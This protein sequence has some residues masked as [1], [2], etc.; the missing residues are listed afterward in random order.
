MLNRAIVMRQVY[1]GRIWIS[2]LVVTIGAISSAGGCGPH[3]F[4]Q[5][6]IDYAQQAAVTD[7]AA[8]HL[9]TSAYYRFDTAILSD[10]DD[11]VSRPPVDVDELRE[12]LR[13]VLRDANELAVASTTN[14][15][16]RMPPTVQDE[17][18]RV[19]GVTPDVA[20]VQRHYVRQASAALQADLQ[21]LE[22]LSRRQLLQ[23]LEQI[24]MHVA[25]LADDQG[26]LVR[27]VLLAW[28]ALPT[29]IGISR[30]E[31]RIAKKTRAKA[32]K[33]FDRVAIDRPY[34][35]SGDELVNRYAP[36][37]AI[38]EPVAR[39]YDDEDDR[40]GAVG[41]VEHAGGIAVRIDTSKPAV[42]GYRTQAKI[43][44]RAY[45]QVNYVWWFPERPPMA[46]NDPVA[47]P[48]DGAMIRITLDDDDR[49]MICESS[50]NCGCGHVVFVSKELESAARRAF[51]PPLDHKRFSV[52][53]HVT[54]RR[55]AVVVGTFETPSAPT[56]P[57][58]LSAA[59]YHEVCR[60]RFPSAEPAVSYTI[61][62]DTSYRLLDYDMLDR[63]PLGQRLGSMFGPDGLVHHAG[64]LE[65]YLLAP[66]G[67]L[68]AGQ[69][70][71]RGTQRIRWDDYMHDD[72]RLMEQLLRIPPLR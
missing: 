39:T 62:Q 68:S 54:G 53:R 16:A 21:E 2:L 33:V 58:V 26:R 41:L 32:D 31:A 23:R 37:I 63:L 11:A 22:R 64:R 51:G 36:V 1:I 17:L 35:G 50:L 38:E 67:I 56:R 42:Y 3:D 15:I 7:A 70:R 9:S 10:I 40:I 45:R 29:A 20:A 24:R 61:T 18:A 52:E 12:D 72:P 34:A 8:R 44:D 49:P 43:G 5:S 59:G 55:D 30:E 66:S 60:V 47:G 28:G 19:A 69:P 48:I 57:L 13:T 6:V 46:G 4:G 71:K 25:P 14:E 65:G 27:R